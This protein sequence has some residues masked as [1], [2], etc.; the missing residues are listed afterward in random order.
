MEFHWLENN[1]T[2]RGNLINVDELMIWAVGLC[3]PL[4]REI[5]QEN[6]YEYD[7]QNIP[8]F[9]LFHSSDDTKSVQD[10]KTVVE[11]QLVSEKSNLHVLCYF[12]S[13]FNFPFSFSENVNFFTANGE[14]FLNFLYDLEKNKSDL[15]L[16]VLNDKRHRYLFSNFKDTNIPGKLKDFLSDLHS[17]KQQ[18]R[19]TH[20][21]LVSKTNDYFF[22]N[23]QVSVVL[24][25]PGLISCCL[26]LLFWTDKRKIM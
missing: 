18:Q 21:D 17:G 5:T 9:I 4:V 20:K 10:F 1:E 13:I 15:P 22:S 16:I 2:F 23:G 8:L 25:Y 19:I 11:S 14:N 6:F 26:F 12:E 24:A 3:I 7:D